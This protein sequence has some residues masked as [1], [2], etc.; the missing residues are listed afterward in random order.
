[1]ETSLEIRHKKSV[2]Y[3]HHATLSHSGVYK[4]SRYCQI[5]DL[6]RNAAAIELTAY[7]KNLLSNDPECRKIGVSLR[8]EMVCVISSIT[9]QTLFSRMYTNEKYFHYYNI[10]C[11]QLHHHQSLASLFIALPSLFCT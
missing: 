8:S 6:L 2:I 9:L 7:N 11:C 3:S 4:R 1:M 10:G 5:P